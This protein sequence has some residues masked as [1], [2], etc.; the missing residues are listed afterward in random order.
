MPSGPDAERVA[1]NRTLVV[2]RRR[3]EHDGLRHLQTIPVY[4]VHQCRNV[5]A[6][7]DG[8]QGSHIDLV[9]LDDRA[10]AL[11]KRGADTALDV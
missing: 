10:Q 11:G 3:S 6:I 5:E 9:R 8:H 2:N 7:L 1:H 4:P